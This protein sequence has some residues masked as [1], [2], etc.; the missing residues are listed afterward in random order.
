MAA[1]HLAEYVQP[2]HLA[3][4]VQGYVSSNGGE[5][6]GDRREALN[7]RVAEIKK[8][9]AIIVGDAES[10]KIEVTEELLDE[11]RRVEEMFRQ[12]RA[13]LSAV[14]NLSRRLLAE[15]R[16][17]MSHVKNFKEIAAEGEAILSGVESVL[18]ALRDTRWTLMAIQAKA[19]PKGNAPVFDNPDELLAFMRRKS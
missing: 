9:L 15:K 12:Q 18:V 13:P 7:R 11:L 3:A 8:S 4:I 1:A 5:T 2:A 14:V 10:G 16:I 6:L 17:R 19:L